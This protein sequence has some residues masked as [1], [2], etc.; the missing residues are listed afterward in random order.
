MIAAGVNAKALQTFM[1]HSTVTTTLDT[2]GHLMPGSED[3]AAGLLD[4][5]LAIQRE[6][7]EDAARSAGAATTGAL[8]GAPVAHDA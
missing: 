5:Y 1:G 8:T 7:A 4:A 3:E 2:Y 6:R